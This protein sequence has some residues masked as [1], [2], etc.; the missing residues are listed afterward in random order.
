VNPA[1][2]FDLALGL[3]SLL[4]QDPEVIM[5]GEIRDSDTAATT[6]QAALTGHLVI[7]TFHAGSAASA[8]SRLIEMGMEPYQILSGV[9]AVLSQ[10]L[11]RGLCERCSVPLASVAEKLD[12][13]VREG[14][15]PAGCPAC[16]GTGYQGRIVLAE[17]LALR[18]AAMHSAILA[19]RDSAE[20]ARLAAESG[21]A[22]LLDRATAAVEAGAT[23][24]EEVRRVLGF[25]V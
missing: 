24:P 3:R 18:A 23:S 12:L 2:G 17:L 16:W 7:T 9:L 13:P 8:I 11:V 14:R 4:R 22:T 19:R 20:L 15:R 25:G 6:L 1:A 5:V 21:C 10:R